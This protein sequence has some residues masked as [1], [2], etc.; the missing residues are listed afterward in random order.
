MARGIDLPNV[1]AVINYDTPRQVS[2]YIHRVGRTARAGREGRSF[3][4]LKRGQEK[5]FERLRRTVG[6]GG[7]WREVGR[8][9]AGKLGALEPFLPGYKKALRGLKEVMGWE[10]GGRLKTTEGMNEG[11][12]RQ[13]LRMDAGLGGNAAGQA[14]E[15]EEGGEEE[16]EEEEEEEGEEEEE[17]EEEEGDGRGE[18]KE[19]GE[20][21]T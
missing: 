11:L 13:M 12:V 6:D 9:T 21:T 10:K 15:G 3:T 5:E 17:E 18:E 19:E 7:K 1:S 14:K 20:G 16:E 8:V 4:F 2:T